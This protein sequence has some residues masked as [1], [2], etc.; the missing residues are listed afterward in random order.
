[1]A[2][3]AELAGA[4]WTEAIADAAAARTPAG[5]LPGTPS[6]YLTDLG[7]G[8]PWRHRTAL[9]AGMAALLLLAGVAA[10]V[11]GTAPE[12]SVGAPKFV[13]VPAK[14]GKTKGGAAIK[15]AKTRATA[16]A[17]T[18]GAGTTFVPVQVLPTEGSAPI[19]PASHPPTPGN[20]AVDPTRQTSAPKHSSNPAPA[21][22][23]APQPTAAPAAAEAPPAEELP[24]E[25]R[26][27]HE[28]P[29]KPPHHTKRIGL[30]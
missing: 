30:N 13:E 11:V 27:G 4:D 6:A 2:N 5:S 18:T 22:T 23:T 29:G 9:A 19:E 20:T 15:K 28:P 1:M 8:K 14:A 17:K 24:A 3:A 25:S 7:R 12:L 21:P 26:H 16:A 10:A